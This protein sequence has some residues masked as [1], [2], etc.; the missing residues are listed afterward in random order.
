MNIQRRMAAVAT[1][2]T[3]PGW[4][5][6]LRTGL[7]IRSQ[8]VVSGN[9]RDVFPVRDG[10]GLCFLPADEALWSLLQAR[11]YAG[12]LKYDP[13]DGVKLH[14]ECNSD[15]IGRL[16]E[17][18]IDPETARHDPESLAELLRK[19][20][21]HARVPMA[22]LLDYASQ[23]FGRSR[24]P[25]QGE[26]D[27]FVLCD[28]I[29]HSATPLTGEGRPAGIPYNPIVWFVNRP[30]DLPD[31]FTIGNE[32]IRGLA[33]NLPD[34]E[35]RFAMALSIM[36]SFHDASRLSPEDCRRSLEQLALETDG[37]TLRSMLAIAE[38]ARAEGIGLARIS[39]AVRAYKI[40]TPSNPWK[41]QVMRA[42]IADG[43]KLLT[44]RVKGQEHAVRKAL[45]ILIRSVMGL[46]GAQMSSR[47]GRP[48]GVMFFAGP[49]GVGK[50]ELAKSIT[51][52]LF[53]DEAAY[54][55]FDMSE[56][57]SE[58]SESR[59]V[60]APPGYVGHD[61][62][63]ELVNAAR[64]RPFNVFLFDEIEKAHPRILDKFLQIIDEGRLTDGRGETVHF[65]ESI[66]IFTSNIGILGDDK[67]MNMSLNILPSDTYEEVEHKI[68][69]AIRQ[70]F[71][72]TLRRPELIN[73]IGQNIVVFEFIRTHSSIL[74][75]QNMVK[76]VLAA[77]REEHGIEVSFT[78]PAMRRIE[79][80]CTYDLFDGGRGIG[81]R[82][83]TALVNP[84]ARLLFQLGE[85]ASG[86][87]VISEIEEHDGEFKLHAATLEGQ[88]PR[89]F[90]S[91]SR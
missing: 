39:D 10:R 33:A 24:E 46:S 21:S 48:R 1:D 35:E 77:V 32:A 88:T 38:L 65:S 28:K 81:N 41:S 30:T 12:L 4:L 20:A 22:F 74:I 14:R 67:A 3:L 90:G 91:G 17:A 82:L 86:E 23:L 66:I 73:R 61:E 59:L 31:W 25:G 5:Q 44:S 27:F 62:G 79:E 50:T 6:E 53:G 45:D 15:L 51:E 49:T 80:L 13:V 83:E 75:L 56:F 52:L 36:P 85:N 37:M 72:F 64:S 78:E 71:R 8:F 43:E 18:A 16:R 87:V 76:K 7:P 63:G 26:R 42:R 58:N 89:P 47:H 60:G 70:Y 19:V 40:G 54:H 29:A 57:S 55:R 68:V 11:G 34:L 84:L 9:L 69:N 2:H